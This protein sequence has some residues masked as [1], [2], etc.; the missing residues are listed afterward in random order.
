MRCANLNRAI[1]STVTVARNEWKYVAEMELDLDPDLPDV[2]C[3]V[4]DFNQV[5]LN[6]VVN[7]AQAIKEGMPKGS[8][9][10]GRIRIET[11]REPDHAVIRVSDTGVGIPP[12]IRERIF[13][14]FFTT[15]EV[16]SGS[17]QGLAIA[18]AVIVKKHRGKISVESERG[19]GATF[20]I[21]LPWM[22]AGPA[23]GPALEDAA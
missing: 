4:G 12:E 20:I 1:E 18:H 16:G 13:D 11:R 17:G 10:K 2:P 7:A 22:Q 19:R 9:E 14:P 6:L 23:E 21:R 3:L 8:A 5:V 15:K